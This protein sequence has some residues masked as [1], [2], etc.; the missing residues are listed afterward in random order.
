MS[1]RSIPPSSSWTDSRSV[2]SARRPAA[3]A[4]SSQG[5][6]R[7]RI[8][9]RRNMASLHADLVVGLAEAI[10]PP[11]AEPSPLHTPT[12]SREPV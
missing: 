7:A 5:G 9:S 11:V 12:I 4:A 6:F 1:M 10:I 3:V 8:H 2:R